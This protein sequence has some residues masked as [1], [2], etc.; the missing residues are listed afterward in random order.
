MAHVPQKAQ[1]TG[2]DAILE[3]FLTLS[4]GQPFYSVWQ[5]DTIPLYTWNENDF[6]GGIAFLEQ[7]LLAAEQSGHNEILTIRFHPQESKGYITN[8]TPVIGSMY[9]RVCPLDL[10]KVQR[11]GDIYS[12][13]DPQNKGTVN[14]EMYELMSGLKSLPA[15]INSKMDEFS[16]RIAKL[17]TEKEEIEKPDMI[18]QI[19]SLLSNPAIAQTA[20]NFLGMLFPALNNP[21]KSQPMPINGIKDVPEPEQIRNDPNLESNMTNEYWNKIDVVLE[22]LSVHCDLLPDL[23]KL[24]DVA[25][26]NPTMFK[27]LLS[28]LKTL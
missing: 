3:A 26:S 7:N 8:K 21:Q 9:I 15:Q 13:T 11:I 12:A 5:R 20:M 16:A 25:E 28:T 22:R 27:S 14:F 6:E 24:A 1:Y 10:S 2:P 19:G 18:G 23:T 17:E 4:K